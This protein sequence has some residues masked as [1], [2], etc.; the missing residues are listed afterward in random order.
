MQLAEHP[1]DRG[2]RLVFS[3]WLQERGDPRG[4]V[5]ALCARGDLSLTEQRRVA[6][7]TVQH[8]AAWLG[9]LVGVADLARSRFVDGFLSELVCVTRPS[10][11][12]AALAGDP[13]LSTVR[14]LGVAPGQTPTELKPF[15]SHPMLRGVQRLE[16]GSTDWR[17][18]AA[19]QAP[20]LA[21]REVV[22]SSWGVF[23]RELAPLKQVPVFQRGQSLGLS[24]TEF[25]N[26]LV[27]A[28]VFEMLVQQAGALEG[29]RA[30]QLYSRYGVLEGCSSWLM[31]VDR[32]G[33][34]LPDL[35]SWGVESGEVAFTRSRAGIGRFSHL[36]I[37]LSLP[38]GQGEKQLAPAQLKSTLEVRIATAASV[39]VLLGPARLTSVE[40]K[41]GRG[42]RLRPAERSALVSAAR[43]S[44]SLERFEIQGEAAVLP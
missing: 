18:L 39:L 26:N 13:R 8:A 31:A 42:A 15:L 23:E 19:L 28:E 24:T 27:V 5:I 40:V 29:F 25:M 4:E 20:Q 43:R 30:V 33:R 22:V 12:F 16:L 21:P 14:A 34:V 6:R 32:L 37:D 3:D 2:L 11:T 7:L 17:E 38:E 36:L 1:E 35:E 10:A 41:L 9:P 44:G